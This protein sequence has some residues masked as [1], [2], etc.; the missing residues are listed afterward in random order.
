MS[1]ETAFS[2]YRK[3]T[4]QTLAKVAETFAVDK[5]TILRWEQGKTPIPIK[6]LAEFEEVTGIPRRDLR[7]DVFR[8]AK[9]THTS[10]ILL[11]S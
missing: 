7:P 1:N 3:N 5:K 2:N 6:R 9:R 4:G 11:E 8:P 10:Q